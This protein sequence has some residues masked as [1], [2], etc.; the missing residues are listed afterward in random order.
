MVHLDLGKAW[1][2]EDLREEKVPWMAEVVAEVDL[3]SSSDSASAGLASSSFAE[4]VFS[5]G[6]E[7]EAGAGAAATGFVEDVLEEEVVAIEAFDVVAV[8]AVGCADVAETD[9]AVAAEVVETYS[10]TVLKVAEG[11]VDWDS[12]SEV[13]ATVTSRPP[14]AP[15]PCPHLE[16]H[17]PHE[18]DQEQ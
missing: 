7:A 17:P 3:A 10:G 18:Q 15:M 8:V 5:E 11:L 16:S 12:G 6:I 9:A 2:E 14:L 4:L 13:A 1:R